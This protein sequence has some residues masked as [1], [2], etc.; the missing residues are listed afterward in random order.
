MNQ[1][2]RTACLPMIKAMKKSIHLE[3]DNWLQTSALDDSAEIRYT[4]NK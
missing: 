2:L 3:R 1:F 4:E